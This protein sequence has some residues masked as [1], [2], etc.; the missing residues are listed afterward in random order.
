MGWRPTDKDVLRIIRAATQAQNA[1]ELAFD[2]IRAEYPS[3]NYDTVAELL[4]YV[5]TSDIYS[6][7][8]LSVKFMSRND[9]NRQVKYYERI[10]KAGESKPRRTTIPITQMAQSNLT[11]FY[12]DESGNIDESA[13][14]RTESRN[15][16][17][18]A[19]QRAVRRLRDRGI[20]LEKVEVWDSEGNQVKNEWGKP[21]YMYVPA[22]GQ[23]LA[24]FREEIQRD[25]T[26]NPRP[27]R[28][29]LG[30]KVQILGD[31]VDV[32]LVTRYKLSPQQI[33]KGI[34][35]D[36]E[37]TLR[38][39][40][41]FAN[42]S[43]IVNS[44]LPDSIAEELTGYIEAIFRQSPEKQAQIYEIIL[45][46]PES[47]AGTIEYLY[48]DKSGKVET[49]LKNIVNY[50]RTKIAPELGIEPP[51][52]EIDLSELDM[53]STGA[54]SLKE[55]YHQ[56]SKGEQL[57]TTIED[58][59]EMRKQ[60]TVP[61]LDPDSVEDVLEDNEPTTR[62]PRRRKAPVDNRL[63]IRKPKQGDGLPESIKRINKKRRKKRRR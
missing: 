44:V 29:A 18:R 16:Q 17:A 9:F 26:L 35:S 33:S 48:L 24:R 57:R 6:V 42:Y 22:T 37:S 1:V 45:S 51:E 15:L 11:S 50:W 40:N 5:D 62:A 52:G 54:Y 2:A 47:D 34:L 38:V 23:N 32:S 28:E 30:G 31:L 3:W 43:D 10:T 13:F 14:I 39:Q 61:M 36:V 56:K 63:R 53:P 7:D 25:P 59:R 27:P 21:V 8:D 58:L 49:R 12:F 55:L 4:P 46:D 20:E 41:Y 19:R 60:F